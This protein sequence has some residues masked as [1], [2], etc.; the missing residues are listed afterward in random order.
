MG[1]K[2]AHQL[3]SLLLFLLLFSGC[4][5]DVYAQK[6]PKAVFQSG[7]TLFRNNCA[8]CHGVH[9]EIIGPML[10]SVTKKRSEEWLTLFIRN[11]QEVILSGDAYANFLFFQYNQVVMPSFE[12]LSDTEIKEILFY[13]EQESEHPTEEW[14]SFPETGLNYSEEHIPNGRYLFDRQCG[15]C[16]FIGKEGIGPSLGSVT[17]RRPVPWLFAFIKNSQQL[18]EEG[19]PYSVY[20]FNRY[21]RQVMPSFEFLDQEEISS[22]LDYIE[23]ASASPPFAAGA[24]GKKIQMPL[25]S[26]VYNG[27]STEMNKEAGTILKTVFIII[28]V[29]GAIIHGYLIFKLFSYLLKKTS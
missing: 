29:I 11:S 7:N 13:I 25:P 27:D 5:P 24:N 8:P 9:Q 2:A 16:H 20:L 15:S 21:D 26:L 12:Q 3:F 10:A 6:P 22:I 4:F 14:I 23:F 17:G 28:S 18:I 1:R 19:D